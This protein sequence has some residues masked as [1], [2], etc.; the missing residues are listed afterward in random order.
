MHGQGCIRTHEGC[1]HMLSET[2]I[3][4]N[5][6][7]LISNGHNS[8]MLNPNYTK[9]LFKLNPKM[10]TF[11]WN[12]H[13]KKLFV[14]QKLCLISEKMLFFSIIYKAIWALL[15]YDYLRTIE[16]SLITYGWHISSLSLG[17]RI[18]GY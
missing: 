14:N 6:G 12:I 15:S 17:P 5:T 9:F 1:V 13:H 7:G 2:L 16:N 8:L 4:D 10:S 18:E 11:Q 3:L